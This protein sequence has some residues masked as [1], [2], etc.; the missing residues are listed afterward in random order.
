MFGPY[1][2]YIKLFLAGVAVAGLIG[3]GFYWGHA[4]VA[5]AEKALA[6]YQHEVAELKVT[7]ERIT[8]DLQKTN[9][10]LSASLALVNAQ[11]DERKA[12]A[13]KSFDEAASVKDARIKAL[14]ANVTQKEA[15]L[16]D[17]SA[18]IAST[19]DVLE[20]ARLEGLTKSE[21]AGVQK[22]LTLIRGLECLST[23]I[24]DDY[25]DRINAYEPETEKSKDLSSTSF[26]LSGNREGR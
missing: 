23:P 12:E 26:D 1:L 3:I 19:T 25:I 14:Q 9:Q 5:K 15:K 22:D 6:D 10:G 17:L 13:K 11:A 18:Q 21:T 4:G 8:T 20:K 2:T 24:P 16:A 7:Q